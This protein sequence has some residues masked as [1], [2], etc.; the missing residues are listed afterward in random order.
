ML[1]TRNHNR[2]PGGFP[3]FLIFSS[4]ITTILAPLTF[5]DCQ[6]SACRAWFPDSVSETRNGTRAGTLEIME[7]NRCVIFA[8]GEYYAA[9]LL[10]DDRALIIAADGGLDHAAEAGITPD[11]I[12]GDFDSAARHPHHSDRT[13]VLPPEKDD[14]DL[15]SA[16][17][18]GWA[19]GARE[20]HIYGALGGRIDHTIATLQLTALVCEHG[21]AAYVYGD[22]LTV[23]AVCDGALHFAAQTFTDGPKYVSAFAHNDTARG[24][25]EHG[26][27]Y[28]LVD[29]TMDNTHVNGVSN[30]LIS[31]SEAS[32]SVEHGTLLVTFPA[33]TPTPSRT[34]FHE[35]S[36]DLGPLS[37]AVSSALVSPRQ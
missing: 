21:G 27:K 37:T 24:V 15:L 22:G 28:E 31:G 34:L 20:F 1:W 36:G 13:I 7:N 35:F 9:P 4:Q 6:S 26:L 2:L 10:P 19:H 23:T 8:A 3:A 14:P 18:L 32:I 29:A 17:K 30:E 25:N 11:Y 33:G 12:V 5:G 16:L